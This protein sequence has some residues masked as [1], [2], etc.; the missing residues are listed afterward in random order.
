M[1]SQAAKT[2]TNRSMCQLHST[3]LHQDCTLLMER[4]LS[5]LHLLST[6]F[7][8][9]INVHAQDSQKKRHLGQ[10]GTWLLFQSECCY[11]QLSKQ[12]SQQFP[13]YHSPSG[14]WS[15]Q[16]PFHHSWKECISVVLNSTPKQSS[17]IFPVRAVFAQHPLTCH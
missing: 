1:C 8:M 4:L 2:K 9:H 11:F 16:I 14:K 12:D 7:Q 10:S 17:F 6:Y 13:V 5:I 15:R 3:E